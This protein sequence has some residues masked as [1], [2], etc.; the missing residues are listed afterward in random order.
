MKDPKTLTV[1]NRSI[2]QE[3]GE[4]NDIHVTA[5]CEGAQCAVKFYWYT[6]AGDYR[7][8]DTDYTSYSI[9]YSCKDY[10]GAVRAENLWILSRNQTLD[11]LD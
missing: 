11:T 1:Y 5:T 2:R 10:F 4:V 6:P 8:V 7:V 3:T 9:V